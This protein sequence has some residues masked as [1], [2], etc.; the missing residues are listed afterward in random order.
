MLAT[1]IYLIF[2]SGTLIKYRLMRTYVCTFCFYTESYTREYVADNVAQNFNDKVCTAVAIIIKTATLLK[3]D[4]SGR[5]G[6][7]PA[8]QWRSPQ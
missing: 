4:V 1:Y 8:K 5:Q 6:F 3:S 7:S 2:K